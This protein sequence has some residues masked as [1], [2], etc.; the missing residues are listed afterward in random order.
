MEERLRKLWAK[1]DGT[2]IREHTD[3]LLENLR[4]LKETFGDLIE[5]R[6]P[7]SLRSV[8][9]KALE[10]ACEYHDYGKVHSHFQRKVGNRAVKPLRTCPR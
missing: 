5:E 6:V 8:F 2:T 7:K 3:R 10:L 4:R 9:W 1:S